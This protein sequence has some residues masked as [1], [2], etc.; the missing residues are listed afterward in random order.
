[1]TGVADLSTLQL[2][3]TWMNHDVKANF[4]MALDTNHHQVIIGYRHPALLKLYDAKTGKEISSQPMA[5]DADD[6]YFDA[7]TSAIY[8]SNGDGHI[9]IFRQK[10]T[11]G[12][13]EVANIATRSGARTSLLVPQLH[14]FVV[15][16]RAESGK[17]AELLV[18]DTAK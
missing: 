12:Y 2:T 4:P 14:F 15:A 13:E 8:V 1:M 17:K 9:N 11:G 16:A 18:Y 3:Q 5:G 6:L 10:V 7:E